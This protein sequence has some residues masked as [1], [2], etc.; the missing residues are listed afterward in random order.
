M[1][2]T[3]CF[4]NCFLTK[5]KAK[6][7]ISDIISEKTVCKKTTIFT[8][9]NG[10]FE[11]YIVFYVFF[12]QKKGKR[13]GDRNFRKKHTEKNDNFHKTKRILSKEHRLVLVVFDQKKGKKL[14]FQ[15]DFQIRASAKKQFLQSITVLVKGI[16]CFFSGFLT[17]I[18][19]W[20]SQ[21]VTDLTL[22]T[23]CNVFFWK[24]HRVFL[25]F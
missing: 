20:F 14:S 7:E 9:R 8:K 12:Y 1:Q 21:N 13:W 16:S 25:A 23:K 15:T 17:I 11:G 10:F 18:E 19:Q 6:G 24:I 5:K 3:S 22:F 2:G 4:Y